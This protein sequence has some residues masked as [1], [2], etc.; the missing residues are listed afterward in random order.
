MGWRK[1]IEDWRVSYEFS[2]HELVNKA[3]PL[4]EK[5]V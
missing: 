3:Q 4:T 1:E 2:R 5:G